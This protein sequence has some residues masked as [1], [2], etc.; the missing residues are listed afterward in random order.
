[1]NDIFDKYRQ[2]SLEKEQEAL[3]EARKIAYAIA[4]KIVQEQLAEGTEVGPDQSKLVKKIAGRVL[5][6][7]KD[8]VLSRLKPF[9]S[10]SPMDNLG[11]EEHG[12][13][14]E[15]LNSAFAEAFIDR[16]ATGQASL[17]DRGQAASSS[18]NPSPAPVFGGT[19]SKGPVKVNMPNPKG[20]LNPYVE[21]SPSDRPQMD[22]RQKEKLSNLAARKTGG[23]PT[24]GTKGAMNSPTQ[25]ANHDVRLEAYSEVF[26]R[27]L[28]EW[29]EGM[30]HTPEQYAFARVHSFINGGKSWKQ[31]D[32][33]IADYL[34]EGR[35]PGKAY[36]KPFNDE[37]GNQKGWK[38]STKW[39]R[40]KY[41]GKD[42]KQSAEKHA[43]MDTTNECWTPDE[44][45]PSSEPQ[46]TNSNKSSARLVGTNSL[47]NTYRKSTPGQDVNMMF[48]KAIA[49]DTFSSD[50][51]GIIIPTYNRVNDD[52]TVTVIRGHVIKRK[53]RR[54]II[55]D[56]E[57]G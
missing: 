2:K 8:K 22:D 52:G 53:T 34:E 30:K 4:R 10:G 29:H 27:G 41:F 6:K 49:E 45:T 11:K 40:V 46:S 3:K 31:L 35:D 5:P 23:G 14:N 32:A 21:F 44:P 1:M 57:Q 43:G 39:G 24:T 51:E 7:I 37:T 15:S 50:R 19:T 56:D 36:V 18:Q 28:N 20:G 38:A 25:Q 12:E 13:T 54:K 48:K 26:E 16:M 9:V 55:N 17:M 42:F 33:D 47:A